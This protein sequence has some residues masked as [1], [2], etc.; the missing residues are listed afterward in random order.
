[1]PERKGDR[2]VFASGVMLLT[3][4]LV[5][6]VPALLLRLT[7]LEHHVGALGRSAL[8]GLGIVGASLLLTWAAE[9]SELLGDA[10]MIHHV[11]TV[12]AARSGLEYGRGI[13]VR[14]AERSQVA[15]YPGGGLEA[16]FGTQ[17]RPV[18]GTPPHPRLQDRLSLARV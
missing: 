18:G 4:A 1:M 17:L 14:H 8:F 13:Q 11:I 7:S 6:T 15:G 2:S 10:R 9:A 16:E 12:L 5:A 3:V